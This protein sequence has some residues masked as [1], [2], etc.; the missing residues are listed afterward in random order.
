M[1]KSAYRSAADVCDVHTEGR[2]RKAD[3]DALKLNIN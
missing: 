3:G 1:P 2:K